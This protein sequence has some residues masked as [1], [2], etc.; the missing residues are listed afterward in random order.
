MNSSAACVRFLLLTLAGL[1]VASCGGDS[2]KMPEGDA[3]TCVG[4]TCFVESDGEVSEADLVEETGDLTLDVPPVDVPKEV[5]ELIAEVE[6]VPEDVPAPPVLE[7]CVMTA[8]GCLESVQLDLDLEQHDLNV[9]TPGLQVKVQVHV[10]NVPM[11]TPI[12]FWLDDLNVETKG[13]AS[14]DFDFDEIT[15]SHALAPGCHEMEVRIPPPYSVSEQKLACADTG[16][17][18][19]SLTPSNELCLAEDADPALAG[20]Q[21]QFTVSSE[22]SDCDVAWFD[23]DVVATGDMAIEEGQAVVTVTMVESNDEQFCTGLE[24][25]AHVSDSTAPEREVTVSATYVVDTGGPAL[26]L[27]SPVAGTVNLTDDEDGDPENGLQLNV[28]GTVSGLGALDVLE[29]WVNG[30]LTDTA[31]AGEGQFTF[32]NVTFHETGLYALEVRTVDCCGNE[33]SDQVEVIAILGLADLTILSPMD[34]AVLLAANDEVPASTTIY[35]TEFLIQA[36][37]L[38]SGDEL[39]VQCRMSQVGSM[40]E[41][42]GSYV[43]DEAVAD[44]IYTVDVDLD[45]VKVGNKSVC[46]AL[47]VKESTAVSPL[48]NITIALPPSAL[49]IES[50]ADG[51]SLKPSEFQVAGSATNLKGRPVTVQLLE[52]LAV[53]FEDSSAVASDTGFFFGAVLDEVADDSYTLRVGAID[54][55]GNDA[56]DHPDSLTE[57]EVVVDS[58]PPTLVFEAPSDGFQCNLATCPDTIGIMPGVQLEVAVQVLG[59]LKPE[60]TSVCLNANGLPVKPCIMPTENGGLYTAT[61]FGITLLSGENVLIA[62]AT[63]ELG[64][65]SEEVVVVGNFDI[66]APRVTFVS[67]P[68]D[69]VTAVEPVTVVASITS[70]DGL[71]PLDGA[72]ATLFVGGQPF[73]TD[74]PA[75]ADG[76]VEFNV[77]G[78]VAGVPLTLQ[79]AADHADYTETGYSDFRKVTL[80]DTAPSVDIIDPPDASVINLATPGCAAGVTGCKTQVTADVAN[81][82]DGVEAIL[83]VN[84][85]GTPMSFEVK[86]A[87][88]ANQVIFAGV[89]LPD[90]SDCTLVAQV[91]DLAGQTAASNPVAVTIDRTAPEVVEFTQPYLALMPLYWDEEPAVEGYQYTVE[92]VVSGVEAQQQ[93]MLDIEPAGG[94]AQTLSITAEEDIADDS[95]V[96]FTF[97]QFTFE[98]DLHYTLTC[99]VADQA[100]NTGQKL[101]LVEFFLEELDVYF[102]LLNWVDDK[103]CTS[104]DECGIGICAPVGAG[105]RCVTPWDLA[106]QGLSLFA[107]PPDLFDGQQN[108]RLCSDHPGISEDAEQCDY[109]GDGAYR[110]VKVADHTGG[111][112]YFSL[113][114][115]E[116][117]A[118]PQGPHNMVLEGLRND[119]QEWLSSMSSSIEK[120]R[121]RVVHI[122]TQAPSLNNL[123][124]DADILAPAGTLSLSEIDI[125]NPAYFPVSV[126]VTGGDMGHVTLTVNGVDQGAFP[127]VAGSV[128]ASLKLLQGANE[129]CALASD[130]VGNTS[131]PLC[132]TISVDT[133]APSLGFSYPT[134]SPILAGDSLD[135]T[136]LSDAIGQSVILE[137]FVD[138]GY[139]A[140]AS[141]TVTAQGMATFAEVLSEGSWQLRA[142]VA[143][144]A[145]NMATAM[146]QPAVIVVDTSAP[147]VVISA[148]ATGTTF[149]DADDEDPVAG[150]FQLDVQF[151]TTDTTVFNIETQRCSDDTFAVCEEAEDKTPSEEDVQDMGDGEYLARI[152]MGGLSN[153]IEYR[154]VRVLV[155]D[156]TG[157]V[158]SHEVNVTLQ[159]SAC[160]VVFSDLPESGY[161]NNMYCDPAG[162]DC[163]ALTL[164][165]TVQFAGACGD[166]DLVVLFLDDNIEDSVDQWDDNT[167]PFELAVADGDEFT[168]QAK[169]YYQGAETGGSTGVF[170]FTADLT[171]PVPAFVTPQTDPFVCNSAADENDSAVGCQTTVE[172]EVTGEDLMGVVVSLLRTEQGV[173]QS[174]GEVTIDAVPFTHSFE[175]FTLP[176]GAGE[177]LI[178]RAADAAGNVGEVAIDT[179]VDV[180]APGAITLNTIDPEEDVN[181]RRPSVRLTWNAV[182]DDGAGSGSATSYE[183]RYAFSPIQSEGD[184]L[185]ACDPTVIEATGQPADPQEP[186]SLESFDVTGLDSRSPSDACYFGMSGSPGFTVYFAARAVDDVGNK[187]PVASE[188]TSSTGDLAL[189][190]AQIVAGDIPSATLG[191][192]VADVGDINGDSMSEFVVGGGAPGFHGFCLVKGHTN[193]EAVIDLSD[194][195][196]PNVLCVEDTEASWMGAVL[197]GLNDVN[198][199][200]YRD[201]G[202]VA[203]DVAFV[204]FFRVYL[205]TSAGLVAET[206]AVEFTMVAAG[207]YFANIAPGGN[208]NGDSAGALPL[209]DVVIGLPGSNKVFVIPGSAAWNSDA[210]TTIDLLSED[211]LAAWSVVTVSA[212]AMPAGALFGNIAT[213]VGNPLLDGGGEGMQYDDLAVARSTA[214]GSAAYIVK[215]RAT[216]GAQALTISDVLDGQGSEDTVTVKVIPNPGYDTKDLFGNRM[217]AAD[218]DGDGVSDVKVW[219]PNNGLTSSTQTYFFFGPVLGANLGSTLQMGDA[220]AAGEGVFENATALRIPGNH[221]YF[222]TVGNFDNTAGGGGQSIDLAYTNYNQFISFGTVYVRFSHVGVAGAEHIFPYAQLAIGNPYDQGSLEFGG[223]GVTGVGDANG[224]G[225]PDMLVGTSS[226]GY[227][228]LAY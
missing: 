43:V 93:I 219:H 139:Q 138:G 25:V 226:L 203:Y 171:G 221:T 143:D 46:R 71:T 146:T 182:G 100:G 22:G 12:E 65:E 211:D 126:A 19:I 34:A 175:G 84:C 141:G 85:P 42:A 59:E 173:E 39:D 106:P 129:V 26:S 105:N 83:N 98:T 64:H 55:W 137:N 186:G 114:Q 124:F 103:S 161:I 3:D 185:A 225:L 120:G 28:L 209:N 151:G 198:G 4:D 75:E 11:S 97:D 150:G 205:G 48:V 10:E 33:D 149:E 196:D 102:D 63:D 174:V 54:A 108:L 218:I 88:D 144:A 214:P 122:D 40:W 145:L 192:V 95:P 86:A 81:V 217:C 16:S 38:E 30:E 183:F 208:F 155:Q 20:F 45:V 197:V 136:V 56:A 90:N 1:L 79:V 220:S 131:A 109:A 18:G 62:T 41:P 73:V 89:E 142:T 181:R 77:D 148:P 80:K 76:T 194:E 212:V 66:N 13:I 170:E 140:L 35:D 224:D 199:D 167:V 52:G 37:A 133:V 135:V 23:G 168:L 160:S 9:E 153:P 206:P 107:V 152:T 215:G 202:A 60:T 223:Y 121:Y 176:E 5:V 210:T 104:T 163:A 187:G 157:N 44:G 116:V 132:E 2:K 169:L 47:Y 118:L 204:P 201:V 159:L 128:T 130:P 117:A 227:A 119:N 6:D 113:T 110:A 213:G 51:G 112:F 57:V 154:I 72:S 147:T 180:K 91:S 125:E 27:V 50:P 94:E 36:P 70:P 207:D 111:A 21:A 179:T 8:V 123:T 164:P 134:A 188:N 191:S 200:G 82:E 162:T 127:V 69:L 178:L 184:F 96:T 99:S 165:A 53:V 166:V 115:S 29:L 101:F 177:Q 78:L 15:L 189:K 67:P 172:A 74:Q 158:S 7:F 24:V 32:G 61:F 228:V 87:V 68:A 156:E 49:V 92:V 222:G 193:T 216:A 17:C 14:S 58:L 195:T 190:Y 31:I